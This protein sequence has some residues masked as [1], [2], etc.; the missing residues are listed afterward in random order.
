LSESKHRIWFYGAVGFVLLIE[1]F[2]VPR[3]PTLAAADLLTRHL[4]LWLAPLNWGLIFLLA[5]LCEGPLLMPKYLSV[6]LNGLWLAS[7]LFF[8]GSW[9]SYPSASPVISVFAYFEIFW[10]VPWWEK[11]RNTSVN[12][13]SR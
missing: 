6:L 13:K 4:P 8:L 11:E 10:L 3:I 9:R 1:W 2:V 5:V 12:A 7:I